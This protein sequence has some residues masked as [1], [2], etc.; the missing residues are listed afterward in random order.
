MFLFRGRLFLKYTVG[1]LYVV[2]I[3]L[4]ARRI[5]RVS[6]RFIFETSHKTDVSS[7]TEKLTSEV[8]KKSEEHQRYVIN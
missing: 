5:L 6:D 2:G 8:S 7:V 3:L 4:I 1:A